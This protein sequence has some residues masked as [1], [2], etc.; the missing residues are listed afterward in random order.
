MPVC[1]S[2]CGTVYGEIGEFLF[3]KLILEFRNS[4]TVSRKCTLDTIQ[5]FPS[6]GQCVFKLTTERETL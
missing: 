6:C 5:M 2:V 3:L 4:P 1:V